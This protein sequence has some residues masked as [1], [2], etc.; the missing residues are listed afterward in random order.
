MDQLLEKAKVDLRGLRRE[1]EKLAAFEVTNLSEPCYYPKT[2]KFYFILLN[3][4]KLKDADVKE[5]VKRTYK[6]TKASSWTIY[7]DPATNLLLVI[8]R[9]FLQNGWTKAYL[10]ALIYHLVIQYSRVMHSTLPY[11]NP[12][13]FRSTIETLTR[14]HLFVRER[15]VGNALLY[16]ANQI[17]R[18]KKMTD[19]LLG[20]TIDEIVN[21]QVMT[22][23][24]VAQ[25]AHSFITNYHKVREEGGA[26]KGQ[27]EPETE[28]EK[29]KAQY[30]IL[31]RG[32]KAIDDVVK[33]FVVY[34]LI[35]QKA[36]DE[37]KK[38]S[39]VKT[40]FAVVIS[41][42]LRDKKYSDD[43]RMIL[44]LYIKGIDNSN[45]LCGNGYD[46]YVKK[47]MAVKRTRAQ[48]YF[49]QQINI[50]LIKMLK[51]TKNKNAY[52][53]YTSQTQFIINSFLAY[54]ITSTFK[55]SIC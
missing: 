35:D 54:Y 12:D 34:K 55:N 26:I 10:S 25:S 41:D 43:I 37:A 17:S 8:M 33:K 36:L 6:G 46:A 24:R 48:V 16:L 51:D 31:E 52:D 49:K 13:I 1:I 14:T 15:S 20:W 28:D 38:L 3:S 9:L 50:L 2:K 40:S 53:S 27:E 45:Q 19:N 18:Q 4:L 11:C 23:S 21:F 7:Q 5:F 42:A 47:L 30:Q 32:K 39:K 29:W 44:K 22:R